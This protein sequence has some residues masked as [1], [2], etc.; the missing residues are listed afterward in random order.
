L[1]ALAVTTKRAVIV[2]ASSSPAP[3]GWVS[4]L[5]VAAGPGVGGVELGAGS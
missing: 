3:P 4:A 5:E 1:I 2:G